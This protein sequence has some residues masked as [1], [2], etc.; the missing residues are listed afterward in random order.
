MPLKLII[1][2]TLLL[3]FAGIGF[4]QDLPDSPG[5]V[6]GSFSPGPNPSPRSS[7]SGA[8]QT[9]PAAKRPFIDPQVADD[10]Y[11]EFTGALLGAT[12][13]NVEM[14]ARCSER[15]T[16]LTWIASGSASGSTRLKLYAYTLP[17]DAAVSFLAYK[18]KGKTRLWVLPQALATAA[19]LFSAGRSYGRLQLDPV[20]TH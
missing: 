1:V 3:L 14:T 17:A 18:L 7:S 16:C 20:T 6:V 15:G 19:N 10:P 11:W 12:I 9:P 5:V 4:A 2:V 13:L 8:T